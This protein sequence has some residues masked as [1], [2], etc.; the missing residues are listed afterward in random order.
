M[1]EL[2]TS[3]M[4]RMHFNVLTRSFV[5]CIIYGPISI[6]TYTVPFSTYEYTFN[7][8]KEL[9]DMPAKNG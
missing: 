8:R 3:F 2:N 1:N 4:P 7:G 6:S 9:L 5:Y